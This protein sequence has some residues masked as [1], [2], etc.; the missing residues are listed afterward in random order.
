[1]EKQERNR[2]K[3][4]RF[5]LGRGLIFVDFG[6]V[7]LSREG[8]NNCKFVGKIHAFDITAPARAASQFDTNGCDTKRPRFS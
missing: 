3:Y 8:K 2:P 5:I 6:I 4:D 7:V 1:M